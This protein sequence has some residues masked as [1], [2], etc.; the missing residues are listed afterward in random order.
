MSVSGQDF[1]EFPAYICYAEKWLAGF[2]F[3]ILSLLFFYQPSFSDPRYL[4]QLV[5]ILGVFCKKRYKV[6]HEKLVFIL[7]VFSKKRYKVGHE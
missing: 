2:F 1:P 7:G 3:V 5:F 4:W 6:G